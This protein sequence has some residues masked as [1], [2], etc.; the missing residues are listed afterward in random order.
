M[1]RINRMLQAAQ[2]IGMGG[3]APGGVS[4]DGGGLCVAMCPSSFELLRLHL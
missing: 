4:H 1:D 2:G 3:G